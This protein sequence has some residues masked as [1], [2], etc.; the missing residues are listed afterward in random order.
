MVRIERLINLIAALLDSPRPMTA[1]EIR[2]RIAGYDQANY[3]AFRRAFE[4]DKEALRAMGIPLEVRSTDPFADQLDAYTIPKAR[5]YLPEIDFDP[6][7]VAALQ[8]AAEILLGAGEHATAALLKLSIDSPRSPRSG[9]RVRWGADLAAEQPLLAPLYS[10]LIDRHPITF[11]YTTAAGASST[12]TVEPYRL[13]HRSGHWYL[14]GKDTQ[15]AAVRAFRVTRMGPRITVGSTG[16]AIPDDFDAAAH[17]GEAWEIGESR[18]PAVIRFDSTM[19]WWPEQ[20]MTS[21]PRR[22]AA[23]GAL[24]LEVPMGNPDALVSWVIGFGGAA[25]IV[26]PESARRRLVAQLAAFADEAGP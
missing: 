6:D 9:P 26:A 17:L 20:N 18:E 4:R 11:R 12:R 13:L 19:R 16:Y 22:E 3:E 23:D 8:I 7:E 10:A 25:T 14:V 15:R 5:Y 24:D 1:E 2:E 21:A